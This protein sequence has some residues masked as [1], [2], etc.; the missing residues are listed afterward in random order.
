MSSALQKILSSS[1]WA[2]PTIDP[3]IRLPRSR[4]V[5]SGGQSPSHKHERNRRKNHHFALDEICHLSGSQ[6]CRLL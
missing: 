5:L 3:Q 6:N 2:S 1:S 4:E